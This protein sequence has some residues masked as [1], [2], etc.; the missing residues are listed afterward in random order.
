MDDGPVIGDALN[1]SDEEL[2]EGPRR[3]PAKSAPPKGLLI[4]AGALCALLLGGGA[5]MLLGGSEE[6]PEQPAQAALPNKQE[7]KPPA[8][9][10][11]E[12]K[13]KLE[14]EK[15]KAEKAKA[16]AEAKAKAEAE[17]AKA[18]KAKIAAR[19]KAAR[20]KAAKRRRRKRSPDLD[21]SLDSAMNKLLEKPKE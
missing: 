19:K 15:A 20:A 10:T 13:A 4:G 1:I 16:Q 3:A 17:K 14:A 21:K 11:P 18:E 7:T 12:E 9:P 2:A 8:G 6:A 5:V